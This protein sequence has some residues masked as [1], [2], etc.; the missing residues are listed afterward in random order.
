MIY[1]IMKKFRVYYWRETGDDCIDCEKEIFAFSFD[2]CYK[3]FRESYKLVKIREIRE[4]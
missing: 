1:L 4:I 2:E 3:S